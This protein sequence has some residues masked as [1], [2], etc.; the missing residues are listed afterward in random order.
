MKITSSHNKTGK[1]AKSKNKSEKARLIVTESINTNKKVQ[2]HRKKWQESCYK[3]S[4]E[5]LCA[6]IN[7]KFD[8][9][10]K[11]NDFPCSQSFWNQNRLIFGADLH[12]HFKTKYVTIS[13]FKKVCIQFL[14]DEP[15]EDKAFQNFIP[16][17]R[18]LLLCLLI[19]FG[20]I[21]KGRVLPTTTFELEQLKSVNQDTAS[22]R[23]ML[24][25]A[26]TY[27]INE[28]VGPILKQNYPHAFA[29]S[30]PLLIIN[31][32][33][34][35]FCLRF[36]KNEAECRLFVEHFYRGKPEKEEMLKDFCLS[37][38]FFKNS[39][40]M[41]WLIKLM[42]LSKP[43]EQAICEFCFAKYREYGTTNFDGSKYSIED[44]RLANV[45]KCSIRSHIE[46]LMEQ[47][48]IVL[49]QFDPVQEKTK[50]CK[51]MGVILRDLSLHECLKIPCS[52]LQLEAAFD[53][54]FQYFFLESPELSFGSKKFCFDIDSES[55]FHSSN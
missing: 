9:T 7:S 53:L 2:I 8:S 18:F 43:L 16:F 3:M 28:V 12:H 55:D 30:D 37:N 17:E 26:L 51:W 33:K 52:M 46:H 1:Y 32:D 40:E 21:P 34:E 13:N 44:S 25:T 11:F 31:L 6:E 22:E 23:L 41:V 48:P 35:P 20:Y 27:I 39:T 45:H 36:L 14:S 15:I 5:Q 38:H 49:N 50:I 47:Y 19:R 54:F 10:S 24:C 42:R 4:R 29:D